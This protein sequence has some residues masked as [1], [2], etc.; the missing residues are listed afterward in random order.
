MLKPPHHGLLQARHRWGRILLLL[1]LLLVIPACKALFGFFCQFLRCLTPFASLLCTTLVPEP[2]EQHV[3]NL[4]AN[5]VL[6]DDVEIGFRL[7][8]GYLARFVRQYLHVGE[9][10]RLVLLLCDTVEKRPHHQYNHNEGNPR[11]CAEIDTVLVEL[12]EIDDRS[13]PSLR[14]LVSLVGPACD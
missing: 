11:H 2:I 5:I 10:S 3:L 6:P 12:R 8:P 13:S 7:L 9:D 1:V 14:I 4:A